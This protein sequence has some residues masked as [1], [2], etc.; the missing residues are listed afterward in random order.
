MQFA[1][2]QLA[3]SFRQQQQQQAFFPSNIN[4]IC[5]QTKPSKLIKHNFQIKKKN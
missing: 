5:L 2:E 4:I 1:W 3:T